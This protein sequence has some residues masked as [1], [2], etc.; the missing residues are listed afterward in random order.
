MSK[1]KK[2]TWS[3]T[4]RKLNDLI[5]NGYNPRKLSENEKRDLEKSVKE[6]GTVVPV[7]INIGS[8]ANIIIGGEQRVKVYA[9]LGIE[10]IECMVPSR[11]LTLEEE[12]ELNLRLNK[13]TGSWNEELLKDFDMRLLLDV[14]FGDEEL[15]NLFDDVDMTEDD[16]DLGKAIKDTPVAKVKLGEIYEL[17]K[18]R[19]LVGD[20]TDEN[21][22][23]EL[24]KDELAD[25]IFCD[26]PFN[27]SWE[28]G[29][30]YGGEYKDNK[31]EKEYYEFLDKSVETAKKFSKP[32]SHFFYW[33]DPNSIGLTQSLYDK[34]GIKKRRVC[35]WIKSNQNCTPKIAWNR[36]YEPCTYGTVGKPY[37]NPNFRNAN[38]ILNQEVTTGNQ[39]LD[40]LQD[41][42]DLW[43]VKRDNTQ[44]Y[45]HP[46]QKPVALNEKPFK[47][48]SAPL[49]IVFSGFAGS[50]SD[51][52][53]CEE[54]NR[55][56]RGVEKDPIFATIVID[57]W[58]KFTNLKAKKIYE[59]K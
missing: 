18:H 52:I 53:A 33:S 55:V 54:L 34:H 41:M 16:F 1:Q 44:S 5:K 11:E 29:G 45:L 6:F 20:S 38:E 24:M 26:P 25:I 56:W 46:T 22:V 42:I 39:V 59:S 31:S 49:H 19:L 40:E 32:D 48:C 27:I 4:A 57:R 14:G 8:R 30:K 51:L 28:Y 12:K 47:R 21:Q 10:S 23:K 13:N 7:V 35:L 43:L 36:L 37:L 17:G 2:I 9:D 58:E 50:G 15:Q 3:S